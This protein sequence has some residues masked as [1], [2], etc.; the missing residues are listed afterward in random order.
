M[1]MLKIG[2][3]KIVLYRL[4]TVTGDKVVLDNDIGDIEYD[5]GELKMYNLTIIR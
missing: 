5:K 1:S 3:A 4:D 2:M